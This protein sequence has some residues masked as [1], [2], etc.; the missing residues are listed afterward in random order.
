M[1]RIAS[2]NVDHVRLLPGLYVSRRDSFRDA[3][4]TTFDIRM[5]K[6]NAGDYLTTTEAHTIEHLGATFLRNDP[7]TSESTV[8]FGP[9]GCRTGFYAVFFGDLESDDVSDI[10]TEM[11][12][13]I[14]SYQ[15]TIPGQSEMECGNYRD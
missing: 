6:P 5:K 9:M 7:R 8:Y 10:I 15:G 14:A 12:E 13:F 1:E 2:F 3:V 11:F 4:V